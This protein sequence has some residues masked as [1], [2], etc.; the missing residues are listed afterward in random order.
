MYISK[1]EIEREVFG[2][3]E[4]WCGGLIENQL[5]M[6]GRG[7]FDGA[8]LCPACHVIH[9][10]CHDAVYPLMTVAETCCATTAACITTVSRPGTA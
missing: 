5:D 8:I 9:G 3:L 1:E 2:L 7:E 6:P 10:R 4:E